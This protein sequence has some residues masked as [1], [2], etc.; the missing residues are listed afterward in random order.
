MS[1]KQTFSGLPEKDENIAATRIVI[2]FNV[3]KA[4]SFQFSVKFASAS[5]SSDGST[6]FG[7]YI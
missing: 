4:L 6:G 7:T 5:S 2:P 1:E 3:G